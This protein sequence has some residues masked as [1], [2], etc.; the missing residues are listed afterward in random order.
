MA[1]ATLESPFESFSG[2]LHKES[3]T[4][5]TTRYG[6][7]IASN[8]PTRRDPSK[9]TPH[10]H[11]LNNRFAQAVQEAQRQLA[12]PELKAQWLERFNNQ[13]P[14]AKQYKVLR[15]FVIVQLT[16]QNPPV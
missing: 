7:T 15:N 8:Y 6:Q 16:K 4:Y 3:T 14:T 9:I 1:K 11:D 13:P 5:Y 2:R 10:Q 12:D